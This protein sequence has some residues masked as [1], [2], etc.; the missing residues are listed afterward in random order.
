MSKSKSAARVS[1]FATKSSSSCPAILWGSARRA[2]S[3]PSAASSEIPST[4]P[5][6]RAASCASERSCFGATAGPD[7][8]PSAGWATSTSSDA[9]ASRPATVLPA[10]T[11]GW[12]GCC[13]R[14]S[15]GQRRPPSWASVRHGPVRCVLADAGSRPILCPQ[16]L[17]GRQVGATLCCVS[18]CPRCGQTIKL[19][20]AGTTNSYLV[21]VSGSLDLYAVHRFERTECAACGR[22]LSEESAPID[23]PGE[24]LLWGEAPS[25]LP[26]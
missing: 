15:S 14:R 18:P 16:P 9:T 4:P 1:T 25:R 8:P 13:S 5:P 12:R 17:R 23:C 2:F 7:R 21:T 22:L 6:E 26:N 19:V 24:A 3:R 10:S 20:H 11:C